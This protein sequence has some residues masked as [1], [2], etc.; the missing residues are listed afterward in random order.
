MPLTTTHLTVTNPLTAI[1]NR[2]TK[3]RV[4]RFGFPAISLTYLQVTTYNNAR[5]NCSCEMSS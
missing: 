4:E 1:L 3:A 5:F 2:S